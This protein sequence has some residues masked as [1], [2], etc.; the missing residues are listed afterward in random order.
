MQPATS[1]TLSPAKKGKGYG[2]LGSSASLGEDA[3][4]RDDIGAI[5]VA[6]SAPAS[7]GQAVAIPE[8]Q[9]DKLVLCTFMCGPPRAV[10][11]MTRTNCTGLVDVLAMRQC[12]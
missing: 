9:A 12:P 11:F 2:K 3:Q 8:V 10:K 6:K 1:P 5:V 7:S 4:P